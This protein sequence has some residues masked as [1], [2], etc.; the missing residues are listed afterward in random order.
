MYFSAMDDVLDGA[1]GM[2]DLVHGP[3]GERYSH[4]QTEQRI[5]TTEARLRGRC[6]DFIDIHD[7]PNSTIPSPLRRYIEFM[8]RDVRDFLVQDHVIK[9]LHKIA[10]WSR[11]KVAG[12][13]RYLGLVLLKMV[14][15]MARSSSLIDRLI[16]EF[17]DS[18]T[19]SVA[20]LELLLSIILES[21]LVGTTETTKR[22]CA[23][24][25]LQNDLTSQEIETRVHYSTPAQQTHRP[26]H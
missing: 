15:S 2:D 6:E 9:K 4:D 5:S 26:L 23:V 7:T 1:I 25:A 16:D 3:L 10:G 20:E 11:S 13:H 18:E 21:T 24:L 22:Y 8:H 19:T 17:Y 12:L 14:P